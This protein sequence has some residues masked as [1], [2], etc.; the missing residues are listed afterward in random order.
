MLVLFST[1]YIVH[2]PCRNSSVGKQSLNTVLFYLY[3]VSSFG[4]LE[5]NPLVE[6]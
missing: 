4:F 6:T 3:K 5:L 1:R 2:V